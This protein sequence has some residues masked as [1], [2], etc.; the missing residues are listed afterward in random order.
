MQIDDLKKQLIEK[1]EKLYG[2][3]Y[4]CV[5]KPTLE[6]CFTTAPDDALVLWFNTEDN[7]TH[8]VAS[9]NVAMYNVVTMDSV[10][11]N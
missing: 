3:I 2:K 9:D 4:P 11:K 10:Q 1:A 5:N 8:M 6:E 7:S